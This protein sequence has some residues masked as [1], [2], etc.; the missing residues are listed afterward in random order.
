MY[1]S[2]YPTVFAWRFPFP[3]DKLHR[4]CGIL[5]SSEF[6]GTNDHKNRGTSRSISGLRHC[7]PEMH[8]Y[9]KIYKSIGLAMY[10]FP[11][12]CDKVVYEIF[13]AVHGRYMHFFA[14]VAPPGV[15]IAVLMY[16]SCRG[17]SWAS[18]HM[19]HDRMY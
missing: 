9:P 19:R 11:V 2:I 15:G 10:Q 14:I 12:L 7:T 17:E 4:N 13:F 6:T 16:V 18:A 5:I 8:T 3:P 1:L